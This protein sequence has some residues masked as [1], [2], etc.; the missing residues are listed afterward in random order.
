[1]DDPLPGYWQ[2]SDAGRQNVEFFGK[3]NCIAMNRWKMS[4]SRSKSKLR[5][6]QCHSGYKLSYNKIIK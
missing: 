1:M 4:R 5:F 2:W 3:V 6:S